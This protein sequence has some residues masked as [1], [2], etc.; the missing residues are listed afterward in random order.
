MLGNENYLELSQ[1]FQDCSWLDDSNFMKLRDS[2]PGHLLEVFI[3]AVNAEN[4]RLALDTGRLYLNLTSDS[5]S[6]NI[7]RQY[8]EFEDKFT[9][10][11]FIGCRKIVNAMPEDDSVTRKLY[12]RVDNITEFE[13]KRIKSEVYAA[14]DKGDFVG[15]QELLAE[16]DSLKPGST[17]VSYFRR[18][19]D[20]NR[21]K[22]VKIQRKRL[23]G[24]FNEALTTGDI[25]MIRFCL[26]NGTDLHRIVF[27]WDNT[28]KITLFMKALQKCSKLPA[29]YN[30]QRLVGGILAVLDTDPEMLEGEF[31]MLCAIPEFKDYL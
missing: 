5:V 13:V 18:K 14:F 26:A 1:L 3:R 16:Y 20:R 30:R 4:I 21:G 6:G 28:T 27:G 31:D 19:A 17:F 24:V 25:R 12:E 23:Q 10:C 15:M 11:D 7:I 22:S 9:R 8:L 2:L 29:G